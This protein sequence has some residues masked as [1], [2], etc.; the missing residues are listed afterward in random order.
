MNQ[1]A[2]MQRLV[3]LVAVSITVSAI[4]PLFRLLDTPALDFKSYYIAG[5]LA[6]EGNNI[7]LPDQQLRIATE[8]NLGSHFYPYIYFPM[9][10]V[11]IM[12]LAMIPFQTA[13]WI[14]TILSLLAWFTGLAILTGLLHRK[15]V[16]F[17]PQV[18]QWKT[19][20][21]WVLTVSILAGISESIALGQINTFSFLLL[22]LFLAATDENHPAAAGFCLGVLCLIK[23]QP[24]LL[25]PYLFLVHR[26]RTAWVAVTVALTGTA[27]TA[28]VIGWNYF[29]YYLKEVM[30][31]FSM[32]ETSFPPIMI[33]SPPNRSIYGAIARLG[34]DS[35]WTTAWFHNSVL[36]LVGI[37]LSVLFI[38]T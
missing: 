35:P 30:P 21:Q 16:H 28:S 29:K 18:Q 24:A 38:L 2:N 36:V 9:I 33:Q 1:H 25:I 37:R 17:D 31:T 12:P 19:A 14:W 22:T 5:H 34:L 13:Q 6:I 26:A 15:I 3:I 7:Y 8:Q 10:A 20:T 27:T 23:P 11:M 32:I 4:I